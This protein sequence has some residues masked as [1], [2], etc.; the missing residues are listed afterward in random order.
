M[1]HPCFIRAIPSLG[2][3]LLLAALIALICL[4]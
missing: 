4:P 3:T 2:S 1:F